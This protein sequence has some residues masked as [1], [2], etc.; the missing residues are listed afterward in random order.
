[1]SLSKE[2]LFGAATASYQ[3]EGA[4]NEGGRTMSIWDTFART[5][6][7][8]SHGHRGDFAC[9]QYHRYEEDIE[10]MHRAG[11]QSYR[12]SVAWPRIL[13][14]GGDAVNPV[15][16]DYYN[17]LIDALLARNIEPFI[18]LYH[19]DLPQELE[20]AG[21]WPLRETAYRFAGYAETCFRAFGD[22][23]RSW[24]TLNEP[25]CS[26]H[27]GYL[28]GV[29][30]PGIKD[31][32]TAFRAVHHLNLAHGL[33][34]R[35]FRAGGFEGE[36][37]ITLNLDTPRPATGREEDRRAADRAWDGQ[38]R[39]Y[40]D[41]LFGRG[42]PERH[43]AVEP[44]VTVP[45][46]QGDS[47]IIASKIDFLGLNYYWEDAVEYDPMAPEEFR[48]AGS[49]QKKTLMGW[50]VVPEGLYRQV[51]WVDET[52]GP[53]DLYITENG[54]AFDDALSIDGSR[55]HDPE[56]V[57]YL[58][59]HLAVCRRLEEEGIPLK[60]YFLWSLLDNFEWAH[61]YTKRFGAVYVDYS[62]FGRIPKDSYYFYRDVIAGT[63]P[64]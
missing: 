28:K 9:D 6:G 32:Q 14:A 23:V 29:H 64:V 3:V 38:S 56:R 10:L 31:R 19:W 8:V 46:Q 59:R 2:F 34:V 33:A 26:S 21:G 15:G 44:A 57:E 55:C 5:P 47:A 36:I 41:P 1:M 13:P 7:K 35:A 20:D 40:L 62:D 12:F 39:I 42:Y 43:L 27:L 61:G 50:D 30:A 17:R 53:I 4:F 51:K 37:G 45:E 52:C 25:W 48:R 16:I 63:E 24:I 11:I 54:A 49:W 58:R 22:R 18:T 60:G